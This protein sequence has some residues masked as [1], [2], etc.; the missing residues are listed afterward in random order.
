MIFRSHFTNFTWIFHHFPN[1][2]TVISYECR[3]SQKFLIFY[4][5]GKD[6]SLFR[7]QSNL[8][9]LYFFFRVKDKSKFICIRL[10]LLL[11]LYLNV[12]STSVSVSLSHIANL[13]KFPITF[14]TLSKRT[15][16]LISFKN[17]I[18]TFRAYF[19]FPY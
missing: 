2:P 16:W 12:M 18:S 3:G 4:S 17:V 13:C 19:V 14:S 15:H 9:D 11:A 8:Y 7:H 1:N 10:L 5:E 6:K